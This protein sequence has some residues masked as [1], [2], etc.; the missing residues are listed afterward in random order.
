MVR[1]NSTGSASAFSACSVGSGDFRLRANLHKSGQF[2]CKR[3][4]NFF[5]A[6]LVKDSTEFLQS[7]RL[8]RNLPGRWMGARC[9]ESRPKVP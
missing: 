5:G 7:G 2:H 9:T 3:R 4:G 8:R 6:A 1:A